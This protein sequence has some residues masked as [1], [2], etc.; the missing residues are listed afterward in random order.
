AGQARALGGRLVAPVLPREQAAGQGEVR[1]EGHPVSLAG[2]D[3]LPQRP[4]LE[5]AELVL[6][7]DEAGPAPTAREGVGRGDLLGAE[8][9]VAPL[10]D[11]AGTNTLI[12][13]VLGH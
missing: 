8:V 4:S 11:L 13:S 6:G 1:E 2:G 7:A 12:E 3:H 10:T 9:A 5:E